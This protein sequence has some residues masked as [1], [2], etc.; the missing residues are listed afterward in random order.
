MPADVA[1]DFG[2]VDHFL[3]HRIVVPGVVVPPKTFHQRA[4]RLGLDDHILGRAYLDPDLAD[5][6]EVV[7]AVEPVG[8]V[9]QLAEQHVAGRQREE[10]LAVLCDEPPEDGRRRGELGVDRG[11][12]LLLGREQDELLVDAVRIE[13]ERVVEL[14]GDLRREAGEVDPEAAELGR[15]ADQSLQRLVVATSHGVAGDR[16]QAAVA[17]SVSGEAL[18]GWP[19]PCRRRT[20]GAP[21]AGGPSR[22]PCC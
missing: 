1:R 4:Q 7:D 17:E 3:Q 16:D 8:R 21:P 20:V 14:F 22:A 6:Q 18:H 5:R 15:S 12:R 11:E 19:S 2:E 9:L 13:I 10:L